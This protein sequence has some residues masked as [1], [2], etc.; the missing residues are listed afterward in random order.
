MDLETKYKRAINA[1]KRIQRL[2]ASHVA[3]YAG[4]VLREL[5][6]D[7]MGWLHGEWPLDRLADDE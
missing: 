6:E 1:L 3:D 7:P 5:G 2:Q 4:E